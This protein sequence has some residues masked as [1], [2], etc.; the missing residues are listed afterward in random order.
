M[1]RLRV[2]VALAECVDLAV[3]L[4]RATGEARQ[5]VVQKRPPL[6]HRAAGDSVVAAIAPALTIG[7]VRPPGPARSRPAS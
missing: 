3:E 5:A 6:L 1:L 7:F 2:L 4:Q